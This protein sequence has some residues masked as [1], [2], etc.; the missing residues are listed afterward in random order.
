MAQVAALKSYL[1]NFQKY[2]T[3]NDVYLDSFHNLKE[4][5]SHCGVE[6]YKN[7]VLWE[8]VLKKKG[9][10]QSTTDPT[11]LDKANEYAKNA[12]KAVV[13]WCGFNS[14][15]YQDLINNLANAYINGQDEYPKNT[16]EAYKLITNWRGGQS[17]LAVQ[18]DLAASFLQQDD[19]DKSGTI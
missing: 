19:G 10:D 16:V 13:F 18:L 2:T 5:L 15:W 11:L 3:T 6:L 17:Q 12:F 9:E 14:H 7:Q 8:Y 1:S 4:V